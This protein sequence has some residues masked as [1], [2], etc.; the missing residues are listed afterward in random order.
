MTCYGT[1]SGVLPDFRG[2]YP[3]GAGEGTTANGGNTL[4]K[5]NLP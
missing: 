2:L 4:T 5:G 1:N 3:A